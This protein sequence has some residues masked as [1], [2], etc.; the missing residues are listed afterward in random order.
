MV[1]DTTIIEQRLARIEA[2]LQRMVPDPLPG[3]QRRLLEALRGEFSDTPFAAREV[4]SAARSPLAQHDA[5]RQAMRESRLHTA[6][7]IGQAL[8]TLPGV[9]RCKAERGAAVW[10]I[11][12]PGP[13]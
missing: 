8:R 3:P 9:I 12:G 1:N 5:L 10:A 7:D 4:V 13:A 2:L 6:Q 11:T